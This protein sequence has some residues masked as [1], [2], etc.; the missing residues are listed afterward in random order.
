[1]ESNLEST[2]IR[3]GQGG[4]VRWQALI[5]FWMSAG[6]G[7]VVK[8]IRVNHNGSKCSRSDWI[9]LQRDQT[10]QVTRSCG[11]GA[12]TADLSGLL[13]QQKRFEGAEILTVGF[14]S[15]AI[16]K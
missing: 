9:G 13:S 4:I 8:K 14:E 12:A 1:M 11:R 6:L 3:S 16:K 2:K 15:L 10:D 7:L 5:R